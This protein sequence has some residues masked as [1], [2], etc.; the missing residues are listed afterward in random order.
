MNENDFAET[1]TKAS[2]SGLF[3]SLMVLTILAVFL[4]TTFTSTM[5]VPIVVATWTPKI[6][7]AAN[8]DLPT[9]DKTRVNKREPPKIRQWWIIKY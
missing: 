9:T 8:K 3:E 4:S 5:P 2:C 1:K 7:A 6:N